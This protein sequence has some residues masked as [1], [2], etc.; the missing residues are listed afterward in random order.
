MICVFEHPSPFILL[1]A[2]LYMSISKLERS[3]S[4]QINI[5]F[6]FRLEL[7]SALF[8][9]SIQFKLEDFASNDAFASKIIQIVF[10]T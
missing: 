4:K 6:H 10:S 1:L 8:N 3:T 2:N 5:W 7:D 9:Q